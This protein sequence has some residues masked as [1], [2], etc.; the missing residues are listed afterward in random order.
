[1]DDL[2]EAVDFF[3]ASTMYYSKCKWKNKQA[4]M[5]TTTTTGDIEV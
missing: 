3:I 1:M 5:V 2:D 4:K